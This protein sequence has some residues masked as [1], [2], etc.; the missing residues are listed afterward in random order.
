[1]DY[2]DH[3]AGATKDFFWFRSKLHLISILLDKIN[4]DTRLK[5]LNL[6]A[7]TGDDID[8]VSRFGDV[9]VIDID[10]NAI[11]LIPDEA[12]FEKK[13]CDACDMHYP[14][15]YFDLVVAFDVL[16]HI[17]EDAL[18]VNEIHRVLKPGGY[19]II[20]VPAFNFLYSS[21]DKALA[22]FRRYNKGTLRALLSDFDCR[23]IGYWVFSL[24]IPVAVQ[25]LL[26]RNAPNSE[27][28]HMQLPGILNS[29]LYAMLKVENLII[30]H[31]IPLPFGTT[32]YGIFQNTRR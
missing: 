8:V 24:F 5:I 32:I 22:H 23:E 29:L 25:R 10:P 16:E 15:N 18:V 30:K 12:V 21:H 17:E 11:K 28:H 20:T 9:Y 19:F 26:K 31:K 6:G 27:V 13:I 14:D 1:M 7:G 2:R 4:I 3:Q